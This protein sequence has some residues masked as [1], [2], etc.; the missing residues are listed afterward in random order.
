MIVFF[1]V[2]FC[3]GVLCGGVLVVVFL[4]WCSGVF[5]VDVFL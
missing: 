1:V 2:F 4:S 5:F 3:G